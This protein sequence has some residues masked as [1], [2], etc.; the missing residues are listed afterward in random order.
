MKNLR[1]RAVLQQ[2]TPVQHRRVAAQ[3]QCFARL[4]GGV[5]HGGITSGKQL[6]QLF[7]QLFAQFVVQVDQRLV[8][9]HQRRALGQRTRKSYALLLAAREF[10]RITI[11]KHVDVQ[12]FGDLAH[13]L[14]N[15]FFAT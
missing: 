1:R 5:D 8:K 3:Q 15:I 9:Q 12:P 11:Q 7:P 4:G 2:L 14:V 10:G 6:R 13:A